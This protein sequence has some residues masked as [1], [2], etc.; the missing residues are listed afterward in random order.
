MKQGAETHLYTDASKWGFGAILMQRC[1][2]DN[3]FHPIHYMSLKTDKME[4]KYD[5]YTLEVL[6]ILK[7]FEKFRHYLSGIEF[8]VL[9]D[10][11]AF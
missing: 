11:E 4:E 10:C 1:D 9:T 2:E 5:S 7:A 6:A 3:E 8:K